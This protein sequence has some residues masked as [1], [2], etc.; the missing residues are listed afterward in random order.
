M[1]WSSW[2]RFR[3]SVAS[4]WWL[5][6]LFDGN[7]SGQQA[8]QQRDRETSQ[9]VLALTDFERLLLGYLTAEPCRF[10]CPFNLFSIETVQITD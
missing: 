7:G 1:V 8:N 4:S 2:L 5:N 10:L 3:Q 9:P 6:H